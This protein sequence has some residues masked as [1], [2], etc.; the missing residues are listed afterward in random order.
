MNASI[1]IKSAC[2]AALIAV[3]ASTLTGCLPVLIGS[4]A[5]SGAQGD[6]TRQ[7]W[8]EEFNKMNFEREKAGLKPLDYCTEAR[9]FDTKMAD[10]DP[11]CAKLAEPPK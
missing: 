9:R 8:L 5:Y 4:M 1:G 7:K 11:M 2:A 3:A 6:A 10:T